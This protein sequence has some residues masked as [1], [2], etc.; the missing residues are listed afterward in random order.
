MDD[1]TTL[2]PVVR[3][4]HGLPTRLTTFIGRTREIADVVELLDGHRLVT[5]TGSGG[6]GKTRLAVEVGR[7][8]EHRYS[9]GVF[10]ADVS[11]AAEPDAVSRVVADALEVHGS[12]ARSYV[13][14]VVI[15]L[16]SAHALLLV[17][18]C[19][20]VVEACEALVSEVI[21]RC[22]AVAVLATSRAPLGV[23]GEVLY[24]VPSLATPE[25]LDLQA[26]HV[27]SFDA[28]RLFTERAR[29]A[30]PQF[31]V[32]DENAAAVAAICRRLDGVPLALELAAARIRLRSADQIAAGL[33]DRFDLLTR[34]S[35]AAVPRQRT[36]E[37]SVAWSYDLLTEPERALFR[38]LSVFVGGFALE[39]VNAVAT[40]ATVDGLGVLDLLAELVDQSLVEV[41]ESRGGARYRLLETIRAYAASRLALDEAERTH[42]RDR[43]LAYYRSLVEA[44]DGGLAS[45]D[46][47]SWL[48][49]LSLE[50][51][52]VVAAL[53]WA[54]ES[55]DAESVALIASSSYWSLRDRVHEARDALAW[56]L[57]T[58][59][60]APD[61]KARSTLAA[62]RLALD[63][64]DLAATHA[65]AADA[66]DLAERIGDED[67][68]A[69]ARVIVAT[70]SL[71]SGAL[72]D[73]AKTLERA[74]EI[75]TRTGSDSMLA[76]TLCA[77]GQIPFA[78]GDVMAALTI[79]EEASDAARRSGEVRV[80]VEALNYAFMINWIA[81]RDAAAL[82]VCEEGL[83]VAD[84][85]RS[86]AAG[87]LFHNF[88]GALQ[89]RRGDFAD[90][91]RSLEKARAFAELSDHPVAHGQ[92]VH[93]R[94][95]LARAEGDLEV[96]ASMFSQGFALAQ[97][98]RVPLAAMT[99]AP[100]AAEAMCLAGDVDGADKILESVSPWSQQMQ[101]LPGALS[102]AEAVVAFERGDVVRA[103]ERAH[104]ALREALA[105]PA[106]QYALESVELLGGIAACA[107][108]LTEAVRLLGAADAA[109]DTHGWTR[110][111]TLRKRFEA[112]VAAVRE[113][114]GT[115]EFER[116]S[117][118]GALLSVDEAA[119]YVQRGRG[120]RDRP[121]SGWKSLT[122]MELSVAE[123]VSEGLSNAEIAERLF[124]TLA[125]VKSHLT[126][127]YAKLGIS[128]RVQLARG[129]SQRN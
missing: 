75:A 61:V 1:E 97:A 53:G 37:A 21:E 23:E 45:S 120:S 99:T 110:P 72:E 46:V 80:R 40:D 92:C 108:D 10:W 119:A 69:G 60:L 87:A 18:N 35:R 39:A 17:D 94:A 49:R 84:R 76:R 117:Q 98:L 5:L 52:N 64:W 24:R 57:A 82:D 125:T 101:A 88:S 43:H 105:F 114:L 93:H 68:E 8:A 116:M 112:A 111:A 77:L 113:G 2:D 81:G 48:D 85:G 100:H 44:A 115:D 38:R 41:D 11:G 50:Q 9:D 15:A 102:W 36:L 96:A 73:G 27:R 127:A 28:V 89:T 129:F 30:R 118:Q 123:L 128:S 14:S 107:G 121:V 32:T 47:F 33:D 20:H 13:D 106:R 74:R 104:A 26:D 122:P 16:R 19:E 66:L 55:A 78:A 86:A 67:V 63:Q 70:A 103:Q 90:A 91:H 42:V 59:D 6:C 83:D 56:A 51:D 29:R 126:H 71:W 95:F 31:T 109:W 4:R 79:F 12:P 54:Q 34:T 25:E 7:A 65:Y 22:P 58:S 62:A 3:P 124:I